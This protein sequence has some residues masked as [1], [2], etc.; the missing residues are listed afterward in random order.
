MSGLI[1]KLSWWRTLI[2]HRFFPGVALRRNLA[3]DKEDEIELRLLSALVDPKRLAIDVGANVG[4]YTAVLHTLAAHVIAIDPHPRLAG[5]LRAFP[6]A[7]VTVKQAV[8]SAPGTRQARLAVSLVNGREA[9][10]LAQVDHG[11]SQENVRLYDV[12]AIT[13]DE[14]AHRPVGFVKIDVEGHEFNVLDGAARLLTEDRPIWLIE[15]EAR[16]AEGAPFTL[17]ARMEE[18]GY[19]GFFAAHGNMHPVSEFD[20][21]MQDQAALIGYTKRAE[22]DYINNFIFVP[23]ERDAQA[24]MAECAK[25]LATACGND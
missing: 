15:S 6:A 7:K 14:C 25:L 23:K 4:S 10:A 18:A 11:N 24:I 12:P 13:L 20:L 1:Q 16:H 3:R 17:F 8:A 5:I 22:A 9:D 2:L 19:V 21:S